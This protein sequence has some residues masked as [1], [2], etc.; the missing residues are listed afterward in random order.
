MS[1]SLIQCPKCRTSLMEWVFNQSA[2]APCPGCGNPLQIEIFPAF[3]RR[4]AGERA[5]EAVMVEGESSCFYHPQKKAVLPCDAC[6]RFVCALCDCEMKGRHLCPACLQSGQKKQSI[7]GLEDSRTLY[8]QQAFV[9]SLLPLFITGA[10]AIF[11]ALR[12]WKTPGSI[13]RPMR[14]AMPVALILGSLQTAFFVFLIVRAVA[15]K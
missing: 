12:Y 3:F 15:G 8:P 1:S 6:G 13:V 10:A 14:W 5:G 2:P 4:M 11:M 7:Q 9:L